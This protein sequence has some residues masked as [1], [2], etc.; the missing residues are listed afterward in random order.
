[1]FTVLFAHFVNALEQIVTEVEKQ[2]QA[3]TDAYA[4]AG[5]A[6]AVTG[7]SE[8]QAY[9]AVP[10]MHPRTVRRVL[11]GTKDGVRM[12]MSSSV[13]KELVHKDSTE[14][15]VLVEI[16]QLAE[17]AKVRPA[18]A[19]SAVTRY[20]NSPERVRKVL[21]DLHTLEEAHCKVWNPTGLFTRLMRS[22]KDVVLPDRVVQARQ[23]VEDRKQQEAAKPV[24]MPGMLVKLYGEACRI[25][26]VTRQFALVRT[27]ID[28]IRVPV[29]QLRFIPTP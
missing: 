5:V 9:Q 22:G 13:E 14:S 23:A 18:I 11:K 26:E 24:P 25:L 29:D 28:D 15:A 21:T 4:L 6:L 7:V 8:A 2:V 12:Y 19:M 20:L 1:M 3:S 27:S 17:R 10:E 16:Q